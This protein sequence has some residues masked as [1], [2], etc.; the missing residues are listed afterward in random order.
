MNNIFVAGKICRDPEMRYS[1]S[2]TAIC[3]FGLADNESRQIDG[4][5][6][7]KTIWHN[8]VAFR[9]T[10]EKIV[11]KYKKGDNIMISGRLTEANWVNQEG[12]E[13]KSNDLVVDK[14]WGLSESKH[15]GPYSNAGTMKPE[16]NNTPT[17]PS[18]VSGMD[19]VP[20]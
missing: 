18:E 20:F 2:G 3:K 6:K 13:V 11:S 1:G 5:W 16:I 10:A 17:F 15:S 14:I 9:H 4:E 19:D 8:V 12:K 7:T